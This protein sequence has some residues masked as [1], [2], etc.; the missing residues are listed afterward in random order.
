MLV[1]LSLASLWHR[2]VIVLLTLAAI[3]VSTLIILSVEHIRQQAKTSFTSTIS[4]TDLIVGARGG[5]INLLLYSV[6]R[7][8]NATNNIDWTSYQTIAQQKGIRW[9]VPLSLGDSHKGYRVLGTTDDYFTYYRYGQKNALVFAEGEPFEGVYDVVL[10]AEVARKLGYQLGDRIVLS[11]GI[12]AVSFSHHD[13]K[14]FTVVGTLKPT[15][16]AVDQTLYVS[17]AGIEAIHIDWKNGA[18][19]PGLKIDAETA[20]T[21]DL[22]PKTITAFLL[23]LDNKIMTFRVQRQ[24]NDFADEPLMA[25]LPGVVLA[26]LWQSLSMV[27]NIL[28]LISLLVLFTSLL[29]LV[30]MMLS[31]L[32]QRQS[33]IAVLRAVGAPAGFIFWLIQTEVVLITLLGML[34]G[35]LFLWLSLLVAHPFIGDHFGLHLST[36]LLTSNNAIYMASI[37]VTAMVLATLP[38]L[39]A[40]RRALRV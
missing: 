14:P 38:A 32:Q 8:A 25:I 22:T 36:N 3:A 30:T 16:T 19:V 1:K 7:T 39:M 37:L 15:G 35:L 24:I 29:G 27:E 4:S 13:D 5:R 11:H 17:L 9:S 33:E 28:R 34:F 26:E 40:Y 10:G 12:S 21:K 31:T 20:L 18:P 23:G 2:K 6:F